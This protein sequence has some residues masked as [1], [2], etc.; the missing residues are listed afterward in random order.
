MSN[1]ERAEYHIDS[2]R[3][4]LEDTNATVRSLWSHMRRMMGLHEEGSIELLF[5]D[6]RVDVCARCPHFMDL[7]CSSVVDQFFWTTRILLRAQ[8]NESELRTMIDILFHS[9]N[10]GSPVEKK[11]MCV[12]DDDMS[13][14]FERE[15][16]NLRD[17]GICVD[18]GVLFSLLVANKRSACIDYIY[19]LLDAHALH[20]GEFL[21]LAVRKGN[22]HAVRILLSDINVN[23][24]APG[25]VGRT[26]LQFLCRSLYSDPGLKIFKLL[27]DCPRANPNEAAG[28]RRL[29]PLHLL[30]YSPGCEVRLGLLLQHRQID[31][32][33]TDPRGMTALH[34]AVKPE[35]QSPEESGNTAVIAALLEDR[36]T[37]INI[38]DNLGNTAFELSDP[39]DVGIRRLF[40]KW[41]H[42]RFVDICLGL[43]GLN[44]PVLQI[45]RIIEMDARQHAYIHHLPIQFKTWKWAKLVKHSFV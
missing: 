28:G 40:E 43:K 18:L 9:N 27:L 17:A 33:V 1:Y 24:N 6:E 11:L 45:L 5:A 20:L 13:H 36:R 39:R 30:S 7:F 42:R 3:R 26:P 32:N 10:D 19:P 16:E 29:A 2:T 38:V 8:K 34:E 41:A 21:H 31:V 4:L 35:T 15:Y 25:A 44:L 14:H 37:R 12:S 23:P 22:V